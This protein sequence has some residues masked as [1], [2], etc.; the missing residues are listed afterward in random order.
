MNHKSIRLFLVI[1]LL[2]LTFSTPGASAQTPTLPPKQPAVSY[3]VQD[4]PALLEH[5]G[6]SPDSILS[7]STS[8][9]EGDYEWH[10]FYGGIDSDNSCAIALDSSGNVYVIG[11]SDASWNGP[12]GQLPLHA[13]S[14]DRDVFVLKLSSAGAYQWHTFYGGSAEDHGLAAVLDSGGNVY[15]TGYSYASWKGPAGQLPLHAYSGGLYNVF[16]LK[17][18]SA[19]AYQW[20]T[21][22]GGSSSDVGSA[23]VLDSSGN[24]YVSGSSGSS[25][26]GPA[27]QL[28]LHA[29]SGGG[30]AFVLK[31]SS[32]GAYQWH[33]FYGGSGT[34]Y[35]QATA[36]DSSGNVYVF[37]YSLASW[38]GPDGQLPLHA[39]SG[40]DDVF[41]L[42]LSSAGAYQWHTFYGGSGTDDGQATALDSSGN[43]Y[44]SGYSLA[45]W[46][47]PAGQLPLH[48]HSGSIDAFVLKLSSAGA[49]QW[50]TFYGGSSYDFGGATVLDSSGNVYV[51]GSSY[52]SWNGPAG[53]LPLHAHSGSID[54][55]VLKLSSAGAYQWHTFYGGSSSDF[56]G[57]TVL[58][59]SGNVYVIGSSDASWNGPAGQLPL[60]AHS[61][62]SSDAFVLKLGSG[63]ISPTTLDFGGSSTSLLLTLT[64]EN[65]DDTWSLSE[66]IPWL[67]LSSS[68][69][70]GP[71]TVAVT[72]TR[73]GLA[74]GTHT[75]VISAIVGGEAVT[76][77][78]TMKV[79]VPSVSIL[80]PAEGANARA[81]DTLLARVSVQMDA[82]PATGAQVKA[83]IP[84]GGP[85]A[86]SGSLYDDGQHEDGG[87]NDGIYAA[88]LALPAR[89][90]MPPGPYSLIVTATVAGASA[91]DD[92]GF[93][94]IAGYSGVPTVAV[95]LDGPNAPDFIR[96][97]Q[98]TITATVIYP[99]ASIH[100]DSSVTA[101]LVLP[102]FTRAQVGLTNMSNDIWQGT[103]NLPQGGHYWVDVRVDPPAST[104]FIDG[105]GGAE[106]DVYEGDLALAPTAFGG[107]YPLYGRVP[108][109][110]C[111]TSGGVP[112]G[113]ATIRATVT[114]PSGYERTVGSF[115]ATSLGCYEAIFS[116]RISGQYVVTYTATAYPYRSVTATLSFQVS[117]QSSQLEDRVLDFGSAAVNMANT[118]MA[119]IAESAAEGQYFANEREAD[120]RRLV[121]EAIVGLVF[122]DLD[123]LGITDA[124]TG[125]LNAYLPG[126]NIIMQSPTVKHA[127]SYFLAGLAES[128][129]NAALEVNANRLRKGPAAF[130]AADGDA[131][132]MLAAFENG[133]EIQADIQEDIA[134]TN[135]FQNHFVDV[136]Q[137]VVDRAKSDITASTTDLAANLSP[138]TLSEEQAY[139]MDLDGR[140]EANWWLV[141]QAVNHQRSPLHE[142]F[143]RRT[144]S[145]FLDWVAN[146]LL[147]G[148]A[149]IAAFAVCD[150]PCSLGVG[151]SKVLV[152]AIVNAERLS[153]DGRMMNLG[154]DVMEMGFW[155]ER[156]LWSN[157]LS[158]LDVIRQSESP[159]TPQGQI[160]GVDYEFTAVIG[161]RYYR[162]TSAY[163]D[164]AIRNT[165]SVPAK[166]FPIVYGENGDLLTMA[167]TLGTDQT[168]AVELA[169][170]A[171]TTVRL[172]LYR[173]G[174]NS[175]IDDEPEPGS[176]VLVNLFAQT[177]KG[178]YLVDDLIEESYDPQYVPSGSTEAQLSVHYLSGLPASYPQS[179][180]DPDSTILDFPLSVN[181]GT[182][183]DSS[184]YNVWVLAHNP[185]PGPVTVILS[186]TVP[187]GVE[188]LQVTDGAMD[189]GEIRWYKVI[190]PHESVAVS[191]QF[192]PTPGNYGN[193]ITFPPVNMSYYDAVDDAMVTF[194]TSTGQ[195]TGKQ[196]LFAEGV[197]PQQVAPA[198]QINVSI[199]VI[200][201]DATQS[202]QGN[203][204]LS[205][206]DL[207]G[208]EVANATSNVSLSA[209]DSQTYPL[210]F[211]SPD[212]EGVYILKA[213][214]TQGG[215]TAIVFTTFVEIKN[216]NIY[217]PLVLRNYTPGTEPINHSPYTPSSPSP[218]DGVTDQSVDVNLIWTG[219]D[220]DGDSVIY[221]VYFEANDS[222]PDVLLCNDA[223]ST[224]CDPGT[225]SYSTHYYWQVVATDEHGAATTGPVWD[226]TTVSQA[227]PTL[228]LTSPND[229]ESWH[230]GTMHNITWSS[231][232]SIANVNLEYSKDGFASDVHTIIASTPNDGSYT[233]TIPN[234]PSTT[235]RM[236]VS[237]ASSPAVNDISNA[238]W[239][240]YNTPPITPTAPSPVNG[241]VSQPI[242]VTLSWTGGDPDGDSVTYDVYL[243]SGSVTLPICEN[244]SSTSCDP[245]MLNYNT[246]YQ[247]YVVA[248]DEY[249]ATTTGPVWDFTTGEDGGNEMVFVPAGEFQMGCDLAHNGGYSSCDSYELPLHTVYLDA[250]RID[251]YEVTNAQYARCV[252]AGACAAPSS[253][254]SQTRFSYYNNPTYANYPV[255]FVSWYKARDYCTW[256][257][258]RLPTEAE[259]EKAARGTAV[260]TYP[261]GDESPDCSRANYYSGSAYCVGDTSQ[262]GNYPTGI[263]P[264]GA[265][266]M[267]DNVAEWVNDWYSSSYYSTSPYANPPGPTTGTSRVL[268][269]G[270]WKYGVFSLRTATRG[271]LTPATA[272]NFMGFRCV[273]VGAQGQ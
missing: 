111:V 181:V 14:G 234:D 216:Q 59:S 124:A 228:T 39:H 19:G 166:F 97:D 136:L 27:G 208:T 225:L 258:K 20:H 218:S 79:V 49:Y 89:I 162:K 106:V 189:S 116:P 60:H 63:L 44:V 40:A 190:Q 96:D 209:G 158:G 100:T 231:T 4:V 263:S 23:A 67:T 117:T 266:D 141:P 32:A 17:L 30:D 169:P 171:A 90:T 167:D 200:N 196:P 108:L 153:E 188:V 76:V 259:W 43:V 210:V 120:E 53:Q 270:S 267:A 233:W 191:Y 56:G 129:T 240:I 145:G 87:E 156:R 235:V 82:L 154:A 254:L 241:A 176:S 66:S 217:L 13:H 164:I 34:D 21:F 132:D 249:G 16:V 36:L 204:Y 58:D 201:L 92:V 22:Y 102:D 109:S 251:K 160:E 242:T 139:I 95:A 37:G 101:T 198:S 175:N 173:S 143:L 248:E 77:N 150:G 38:N 168:L 91:A 186:Q 237:D 80:A 273:G 159:D 148:G 11:S 152:D 118:T 29:H 180:S 73:D 65:S 197:P 24:V 238:N 28:P 130:Y 5:A 223:A 70:V 131:D 84:L 264:Y 272:N 15:V 48:A 174:L 177:D 33:T 71:A 119:H 61:G 163:A 72:V 213:T 146:L 93:N 194:S 99:D 121:A 222:T 64:P 232:G 125:A 41:V 31:L 260:R 1:I 220:T 57:A 253:Y 187:S 127:E 183:E 140:H 165:G 137:P 128:G 268:R 256:A 172:I 239:S 261:W 46:N 114:G 227:A 185:T 250:Y 207:T 155:S 103:Y 51:I 45:S 42:K 35:G 47:G 105:Y 214:L 221:D 107:P 199:D 94:I 74:P 115:D 257:D 244:V 179:G 255:I 110:L 246:Q 147:W 138:F 81:A 269:G 8:A 52:A 75:G 78:V 205:L 262:V 12:T 3:T 161:G 195:I 226:F 133:D 122:L 123:A 54:A 271:G 178:V 9:G 252:A 182:K 170:G 151:A 229:G 247:W 113:E 68:S 211:A 83:T 25:W 98:M 265:L 193:D 62:G 142:A 219:G 10:T 7:T 85:W 2:S 206:T 245:G 135:G 126:G 112:F 50:H 224:S 184:T 26:N 157:T 212:T 69:G 149:D 88:P 215:S 192:Q 236:R 203:L 18:S 86:V 55:F 144:D 202:H 104:D 230:V 6:L 134:A 243:V